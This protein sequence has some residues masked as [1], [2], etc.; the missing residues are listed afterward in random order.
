V[1]ELRNHIRDF[2]RYIVEQSK[3][4]ASFL[5]SKI[6]WIVIIAVV[7]IMVM[8]FAP[9]IFSTISQGIPSLPDVPITPMP[10]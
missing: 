6:F 7:L 2:A 3:P 10:T 9:T 1:D 5:Q 4:K 8:L